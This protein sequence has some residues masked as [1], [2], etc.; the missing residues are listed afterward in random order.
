MFGIFN[1]QLYFNMFF[2]TYS[3]FCSS[4]NDDLNESTALSVVNPHYN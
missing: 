3:F 4:L 1:T 2:D